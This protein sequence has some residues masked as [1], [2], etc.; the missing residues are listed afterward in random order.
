M[1]AYYNEDYFKYQKGH[2]EFAAEA[3]YNFFQPYVK[4]TDNVLDFGSGGG[5]LLKRLSAKEKL[6]S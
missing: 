5:F 1:D 2:G 6:G 3:M 4:E